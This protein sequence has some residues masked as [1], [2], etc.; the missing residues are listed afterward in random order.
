VTI[1]NPIEWSGAQLAQVAHAIGTFGRSLHH[2]EDRVHSPAPTIRRI[3]VAD[4][5]EVLAKGIDDF[6]AYRSD[7]LFLGVIYTVVGLVLARF[8]FGAN[9]VPLLFPLASGFALIGPLAMVGLY[10]MSRRREQGA[11]VSWANGFDMMR[12]PALGAIAVLGLIL[13]V[14]F[15]LWLMAAWTIYNHT[16]GP[17]MPASAGAFVHDVFGT[18]AGHELI[19]VGVGAGFVFALIAMLIGTVSFPLLLDRDVGLDTAIATSARAVLANPVPMAAWG[20]IVAGSLIVGSIPFF[21]GLVVVLPA[22]G[23]STWHLY[24]KLV[25]R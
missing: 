1:K 12:E 2:I 4:L 3:R 22:L 17:A 5:R 25:E 15:V 10:E 21:V 11:K 16:L 24:R 6:G 7:V 20:L 8:S 14:I 13:M 23:H 18:D 9:L 19:A